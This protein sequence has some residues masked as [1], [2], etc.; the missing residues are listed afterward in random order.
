MQSSLEGGHTDGSHLEDWHK[1]GQ[2]GGADLEDDLET[3][4]IEEGVTQEASK[5]E[6]NLKAYDEASDEAGAQDGQV[7]P[8]G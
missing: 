5:S 4:I 7:A 3:G 2:T 8:E 6:T 1:D